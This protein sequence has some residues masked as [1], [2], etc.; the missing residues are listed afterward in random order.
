MGEIIIAIVVVTVI[1]IL[2]SVML[3]AASH[4]MEV[5][6][7][8]KEKNLRECLP[9]VNCGA[10]GYT[11][12][13]GYA[14]ALADGSTTKVNLCVPGSD[15]VANDIANVLGVE[16]EDVV[17]KVAFIQCIGDCEHRT[18]KQVYEGI[19]SCAAAKQLYGGEASCTYGCIGL[20]DCV[21]VCPTEAI[22]IEN[23]IAHIDPRKCIGCGLCAK[24]CP[25]NLMIIFEDY[26]KMAVACSNREKGAVARKKCDHACIKCHKCEKSCPVGAISFVDNLPVIDLVKCIDCGTCAEVC[27]V[28]CIVK[29]NFIGKNNIDE[30][31]TV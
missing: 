31:E 25:N 29:N 18:K 26:E 28:K 23:G 11:G 27:P 30:T 22:C 12:C 10:C 20:G 8:E 9:G 21:K 19:Q 17:E 13:D 14:K 5:P 15:K 16:A 7:D 4:F 24:A 2:C 6:V 1:G 3:V